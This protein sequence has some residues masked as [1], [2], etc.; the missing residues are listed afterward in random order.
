MVATEELSKRIGE[1]AWSCEALGV[2]RATLYRRRRQR[3]RAAR[4]RP[5]PHR[6]LGPDERQRVLSALHCDRFIDRA[7]AQIWATLLDDGIYY[8]SI[9]TMYRILDEE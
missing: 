1:T 7:P 8:C 2:S 5:K 3:V 4:P 9:R 6:A